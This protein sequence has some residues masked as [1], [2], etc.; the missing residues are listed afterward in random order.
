MT[1]GRTRELALS[2]MERALSEYIVRGKHMR[3]NIPFCQAIIKDPVFRAGKATTRFVEDFLART[4]KELFTHKTDQRST[5][6]KRCA[7]RI[8]SK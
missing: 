1:F 6:Q 8:L 2:R 7:C 4:P 5:T 3:T